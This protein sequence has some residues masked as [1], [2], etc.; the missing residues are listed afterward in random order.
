MVSNLGTVLATGL[1]V[2]ASKTS[3]F[4]AERRR[5]KEHERPAAGAVPEWHSVGQDR[6]KAEVLGDLAGTICERTR[7]ELG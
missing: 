5:I 2:R 4:P 6:P 3:R 7:G 1:I